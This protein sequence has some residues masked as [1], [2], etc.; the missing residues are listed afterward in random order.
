M[1]STEQSCYPGETLDDS[2]N[3]SANTRC[4]EVGWLAIWESKHLCLWIF[5]F[6]ANLAVYTL[7]PGNPVSTWGC[8]TFLLA[9]SL[10][11]KRF[12]GAHP[13]TLV[14]GWTVVW[15]AGECR[16]AAS[17]RPHW[18]ETRFSERLGAS[19][20]TTTTSCWLLIFCCMFYRVH[21]PRHHLHSTDD[22]QKMASADEDACSSCS[23]TNFRSEFRGHSQHELIT[24]GDGLCQGMD[25]QC[26]GEESTD[27][28]LECFLD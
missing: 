10:Q 18:L 4:L 6:P 17:P 28:C 27:R 21:N 22:V 15:C 9:L 1:L 24:I 16:L 5:F 13:C 12:F 3:S 7:F 26:A 19:I 20:V 2:F 11:T 23:W 8:L 14:Q 25:A